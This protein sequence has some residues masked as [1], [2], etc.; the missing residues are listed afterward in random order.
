MAITKEQIFAAADELDAAGQNPTLAGIRKA[1]GGGSFSSIQ[2]LLSEWK[3]RKAAKDSPLREPAPAAIA[4]RLSEFGTDVWALA[5]ELANGRLANERAA[6][7]AARAQLEAEKQ[8]AAE[9][10]DQISAELESLK[11]RA[12]TLEASE[13]AVRNEIEESRKK[14]AAMS[15][16]A[17]T[18]EARATEIERRADNLNT[19]L[20][21]VNAQNSD[22]VKTLAETIQRFESTRR[23]ESPKKGGG[24]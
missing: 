13:R 4:E 10:A 18:A 16:R 5:L 19:E 8:E 9:M 1:L 20:A 3:A 24:K 21:R 11:T 2:P 12:T 23:D 17:A 7:E 22:L 15:E 6:L 14:L